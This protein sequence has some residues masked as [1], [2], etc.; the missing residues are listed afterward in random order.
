MIETGE[1]DVSDLSA[2]MERDHETTGRQL[3]GRR[4]GIV[5]A[6]VNLI[7]VC[8]EVLDDF[9]PTT[10]SRDKF[11]DVVAGPCSDGRS[12]CTAVNRCGSTSKRNMRLTVASHEEVVP[13]AKF[14]IEGNFATTAINRYW[15]VITK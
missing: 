11:K 13:L 12:A 6:D 1:G 5:A 9:G 15:P 10:V 8:R 14:I 3:L 2:V 7:F 4:S